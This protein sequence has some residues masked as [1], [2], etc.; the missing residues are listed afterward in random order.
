[1]RRHLFISLAALSLGSLVAC[2]SQR[3]SPVAPPPDGSG[4]PPPVAAVAGAPQAVAVAGA[5]CPQLP[6]APGDPRERGVELLLSGQPREASLHLA[7]VVRARPND[8]A[9][10]AFL[11]AS[12]ASLAIANARS[13]VQVEAAPVIPLDRIPLT[14]VADAARAAPVTGPKVQLTRESESKNLITD[15]A[16][17]LAKHGLTPREHRGVAGLPEHVARDLRGQRVGEV[18]RSPDHDVA[19]YGAALVVSAPGK[20]PRV[21]DASA[22]MRSGPRPFDVVFAQLAGRALVV[23]LAY[24]GY[25]KES[26]N[27]NG[28]IA[29]FDAQTGRLLWVSE[30]LTA[31]LSNF[32]VAGGSLI[33]GYGFTAEPDFLFVLDLATGAVDQKIP[34]KSGPSWILAK[35]DRIFLRAYDTD[36]V[37]RASAALPPAPAAELAPA[38]TG[39]RAADPE[40]RCWARAAVQAID[41]RDARAL[42]EA[43]QGLAARTEDRALV[44]ALDKVRVQME[45]RARGGG[46]DLAASAPI[47]LPA[48]PWSYA[49]PAPGPLPAGKPPALVRLAG[50]DADPVRALDQKAFQEDRPFFIAPIDN[51]KLPAGARPDIPSAYG[52]ESLRAILPSGDR[53][54]LV[55]GGRYLAMVK[56][57]LVERIF[58]LDG[59]RHPPDPNPQWKEFAVQDVTYAQVDGGALYVCNG[60]GSYAKEVKGKKGFLS[61][62]DATT[63]RLLWRSEPL[64]CNA[65]FVLAG[66]YLVTGYGFTAEPDFLFLVRRADG[67]VVQRVKLDTGPDEIRIKGNRILVEAYSNR[68]LFELKP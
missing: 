66:D 19:V 10:E 15:D 25:A 56:G 6:A 12:Q 33:A 36:Y 1:M 26:G 52:G 32:H 43:V 7:E 57:D 39:A 29:A 65:T 51:G 48:P 9:A 3:P 21:F 27:Q 17:W 2:G 55:Y 28:Y 46:L 40:A 35:G 63:G 53:T 60:G 67:K 41:R 49:A 24:N 5:A 38:A 45:A 61:A 44:A 50:V 37:F 22:A 11:A 23:Q 68:Y 34:L 18:F 16:D 20:A 14:R 64:V 31:N 54:L 62:L 58:D 47:A 8:A 42:G 13:T 30:P 59:F 4:Q